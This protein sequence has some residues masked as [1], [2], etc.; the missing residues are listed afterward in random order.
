VLGPWRKS[1]LGRLT[2]ASL[3]D[4]GINESPFV[5]NGGQMRKVAVVVFAALFGPLLALLWLVQCSGPS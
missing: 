4:S 1:G 3:P 5:L 2:A